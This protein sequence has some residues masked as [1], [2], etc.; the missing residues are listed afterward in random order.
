MPTVI[1]N[2]DTNDVV[3]RLIFDDKLFTVF[4]RPNPC[5]PLT[6]GP[7]LTRAMANDDYLSTSQPREVINNDDNLHYHFKLLDVKLAHVHIGFATSVE[8]PL[9]VASIVKTLLKI[10]IVGHASALNLQME[11]EKK[12]KA[13]LCSSS[14]FSSGRQMLAAVT[15][16]AATP[17]L[18]QHRECLWTTG[19]N[20]EH[21]QLIN[22]DEINANS[23][24]L[25]EFNDFIR[26]AITAQATLSRSA[27]GNNA[28]KIPET[29]GQAASQEYLS[30]ML[31]IMMSFYI[32]RQ[33]FQPARRVFTP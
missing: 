7:A 21:T 17:Q 8:N 16:R 26:Q 19:N 5:D 29:T 15:K 6:D 31:A 23:L 14:Y 28:V 12:F 27:T 4:Y 1:D 24:T 2:D 11:Y 13:T 20:Y 22:C 33:L 10:H 32:M 25:P 3:A 30:L 9:A 18:S